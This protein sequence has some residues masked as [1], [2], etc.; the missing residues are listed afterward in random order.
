MYEWFF[1]ALCFLGRLIYASFWAF[2]GFLGL[3]AWLIA[4]LGAIV[5]NLFIKPRRNRD[6]DK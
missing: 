1:N 5:I 6:G 2:A 4:M 3:A